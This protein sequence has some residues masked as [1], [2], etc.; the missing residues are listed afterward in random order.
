MYKLGFRGSVV[1]TNATRDLCAIMLAD[2]AFIQEHDTITF[3]KRRA[4]KGLPLVTPIYTQEDATACMSLF[5]GVPNE[6]KFRIDDNIKV[7]FTNTGHMLGSGVA[8]I[9]IIENGQIKRIAY[10][11]DIGRPADP[12]LAPPQ[13]FPQADILITE[14]TYGDRL[15]NDAQAAEE[16]LL[17]HCC[18]YVC[19]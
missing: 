11:G 7:K 15:H 10:T 19:Q 9:Q 18:R 14:S 4:K 5:I 1:C 3:N 17:E 12:I 13:P 8:N 6:M 2:S 16:E